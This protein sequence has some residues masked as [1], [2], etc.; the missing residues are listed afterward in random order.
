MQRIAH[1]F[2]VGAGLMLALHASHAAADQTSPQD[3]VLSRPA[4]ADMRGTS[5]EIR[6]AFDTLDTN[7]DSRLGREEVAASAALA[8]DFAR[9]DR[10][11]DGTLT[12]AEYED[13][14]ALASSVDNDVE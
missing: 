7:R 1:C 4:Q 2:T 11:G 3:S 10:D 5:T 12:R 9:Y 6:P 13:Y 14:V 8:T